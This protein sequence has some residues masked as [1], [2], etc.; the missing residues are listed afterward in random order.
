MTLEEEIKLLENKILEL[1]SNLS[2]DNELF[3]KLNNLIKTYRSYISHLERDNQKNKSLTL[4]LSL[5][6]GLILTAF[7]MR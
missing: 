2:V 7:F 5:T 4:G 1:E 3:V 6:S